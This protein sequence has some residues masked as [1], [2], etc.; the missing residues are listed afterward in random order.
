MRHAVEKEKRRGPDTGKLLKKT[1]GEAYASPRR[2]MRRTKS[3]AGL[4][5]T[6]QQRK[7]VEEYL[8]DYNILEAARR[9]GYK[10]AK[11][12]ILESF[13]GLSEFVRAAQIEKAKEM[14]RRSVTS[15]ERVLHELAQTAHFSEMDFIVIEEVPDPQDKTKKITW[16]RFKRLEELTPEQSRIIENVKCAPDGSATYSLP[17]R[18]PSRKLIGLHLGM[19]N[20]KL[21]AEH[22]HNQLAGNA[23]LSDVPDDVLDNLERELLEYTGPQGRRAIGEYALRDENDY[24]A[25]GK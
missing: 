2:A 18:M 11:T 14:G 17:D 19:F 13:A 12:S 20:S 5:T 10:G 22:R 3:E 8:K 9:A 16:R 6:P 15:Q 21:I 24:K 25:T 4:P 7:F 1:R 23:D